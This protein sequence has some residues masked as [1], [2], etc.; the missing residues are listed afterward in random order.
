MITTSQTAMAE[1]E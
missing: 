1:A